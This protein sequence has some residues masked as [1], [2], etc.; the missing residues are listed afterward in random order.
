M[1]AAEVPAGSVE[2]APRKQFW[3]FHN[4]SQRWAVIVA[5]RRA[6][7]TVATVMDLIT[8]AL[9]TSKKDARYAYIAPYFGQAKAVAWDYLKRYSRPIAEKFSESELS[10]ELKNGSRI[11][12]FGADNPDA[13]RGMYLD[14]VVLDEFADMRPSLWGEVIRPLLAD[15]NGWAVFIGTPK[16]RNVFWDIYDKATRDDAWYPLVLKASETGLIAQSELDD[17][18]KSMTEAQYQQEFECSFEAAIVGAIYAKELGWA[19]AQKR[20]TSVPYDP[21]RPVSTAWDLGYGDST[22][23]W[24]Y[25][26]QGTTIRIFD[27]YE[28]HGEPI[29]HYLSLLKSKGYHY[30]TAIMPHDADSNGKFATG[31]SIADQVRANGFAVTVLKNDLSLEN[32]INHARLVFPR[33]QFDA[34][35]CDKGIEALQHYRWKYNDRM[36]EVSPT[37]EH[38]WASHGADAFRYLALGVGGV[39][40]KHSSRPISY[41]KRAYA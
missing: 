10:V 9:A 11:R 25:Q 16:G 23:I 7:K 1:A 26:T 32:G 40:P 2:Y 39:T 24:F 33:C 20:I 21:A 18:K 13:L 15:R 19:R 38:D 35:R 29:T 6:G 3:D 17:A 31:K 22:A 8:R 28:N 12:L 5:H 37:P 34:E 41:P 36:G 27:Y 30:E 4:R 14:G